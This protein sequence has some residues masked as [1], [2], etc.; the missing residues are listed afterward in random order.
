MYTHVFTA[1]Y[2]LVYEDDQEIL[3][4]MMICIYQ[5]EADLALACSQ[6]PTLLILE[7]ESIFIYAFC[8]HRYKT[9]DWSCY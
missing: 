1:I 2:F 6:L 3:T 4:I 7:V 8:S 5:P 9:K